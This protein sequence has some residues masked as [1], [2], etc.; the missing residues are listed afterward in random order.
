MKGGTA[1]RS[2]LL[3]P[4]V[5]PAVTLALVSKWI[6]NSDYGIVSYWLQQAGLLEAR[7]SLLAMQGPAMA[8]G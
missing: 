1:L 2:F 4:Y 5:V 7:Q 8:A 3:I 6:M